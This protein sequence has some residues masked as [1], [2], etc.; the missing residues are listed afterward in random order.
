METVWGLLRAVPEPTPS[1]LV[2]GI[3]GG[4]P[5]VSCT[6]CWVGRPKK[7]GRFWMLKLACVPVAATVPETRVNRKYTLSTLAVAG[8]LPEA[9]VKAVTCTD[10]VCPGRRMEASVPVKRFTGMVSP[11]LSTRKGLGFSS[12]AFTEVPKDSLGLM[13]LPEVAN[14][15]SFVTSENCA[16]E[17]GAAGTTPSIQS[18]AVVARGSYSSKVSVPSG[19]RTISRLATC[20]CTTQDAKVRLRIKAV[21]LGEKTVEEFAT[22]VREPR[23]AVCTVTD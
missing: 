1:K 16:D 12:V 19:F 11:L 3:D 7:E 18:P 15:A 6:D 2:V 20:P 22:A 10:K 5:G 9:G 14:T 8:V 13:M 21:Q 23:V 4:A 17:V